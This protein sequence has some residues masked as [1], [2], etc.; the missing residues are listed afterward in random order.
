MGISPEVNRNGH[1]TMITNNYLCKVTQY[2]QIHCLSNPRTTGRYDF[3][4]ATMGGQIPWLR[5]APSDSNSF[6]KKSTVITIF[7]DLSISLTTG[8]VDSRRLVK[9]RCGSIIVRIYIGLKLL[10]RATTIKN[11]TY[12]CMYLHFPRF[13]V[14]SAF[15]KIALGIRLTSDDVAAR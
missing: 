1:Q 9:V 11:Y 6:S 12:R 4:I 7:R 10:F 8:G 15:H 2:F 5:H 13:I 14:V 3:P